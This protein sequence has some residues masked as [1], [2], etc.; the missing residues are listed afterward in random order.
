MNI[1]FIRIRVMYIKEALM[2]NIEI[3]RNKLYEA[4]DKGNRFEI[5]SVSERLDIEIVRMMKKT[6]NFRA[7]FT[8]EKKNEGYEF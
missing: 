2:N 7:L 4:I 1:A 8:K 6:R 5:V 3:L